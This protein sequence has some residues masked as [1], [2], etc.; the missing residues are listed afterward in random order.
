[1]KSRFMNHDDGHHGPEK[2]GSILESILEQSGLNRRATERDMLSTW[3]DMVGE[4]IAGHTKA[5]DFEDG[6]LLI[7][8]DHVAWRQELTL[9]F[10]DI[11]R[12]YA[13][14]FGKNAVRDIRWLQ[15]P[16]RIRRR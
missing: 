16:R 4:R 8:A 2:V 12:R 14:R 7:E 6:I 9:L 1:L 11:L 15:G 3:D 5:V 10:P 13:E